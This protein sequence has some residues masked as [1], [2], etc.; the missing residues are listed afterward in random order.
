MKLFH[1]K[2]TWFV[3]LLCAVFAFVVAE[4]SLSTNIAFAQGPTNIYWVNWTNTIQRADGDGSNVQTLA[5]GSN[6]L[7]GIAVDVANG[8]IYWTSV[9]GGQI[10]R[11]DLV[12]SNI[13]IVVAGLSQPSDIGLD[14][15]NNHMYWTENNAGLIKRSNLDG[16]NVQTLINIPTGPKELALDL[17]NN[18]IYWMA[19]AAGVMRANLDG[20]NVQTIVAT[21][22]SKYGMAVDPAN[23]YIF[24]T[25]YGAGAVY[26][27]NLDG[28]N[29]QTIASG[30]G[31]LIGLEVDS[32]NGHI[33]FTSQTLGNIHR[34]NLDGSNVQTIISGLN[35]PRGLALGFSISPGSPSLTMPSDSIQVSDNLTFTVPVILT[36]NGINLP[37]IGFSVDYDQTCATFNEAD[38]DAD[39]LFDAIQD[40]PSGF[41]AEASHAI[42]DTDG[43][44]DIAIYYPISPTVSLSDG[45]IANIEFEVKNACVTTD[46]SPVNMDFNF[47]NDPA[48][49]FA[50]PDG[51]DVPGTSEDATIPV[52]FNT[53]P[54]DIALSATAIDENLASGTV[55]GSLST[56]DLEPS[57]VHSYSLTGGDVGDFAINGS[58]LE[59]AA[60]FNFEVK[61]SYAISITT[62][63]GHGGTFEKE[64]TVTVNDVNDTPTSVGLSN[65]TIN[66]HESAGTAVGA[67]V[68]VD[69]DAGATHTYAIVGGDTADFAINGADLETAAEFNYEVKASYAI[70]VRTTD[71][72][73][74]TY[75]EAFTISVVDINDAPVALNDPTSPI[76]SPIIIDGPTIIDVLA[77]DTDE[78]P[79]DTLTVASVTNG[80]NGSVVNNSTDV[81]YTP[82]SATF[83]GTD[84]F[85]YVATDDNGLGVLTDGATVDVAIVASDPRGDCNTSGNVGI[86]DLVAIVIEFFDGD[87]NNNW[88]EIYQAGYPGSP[89]GCDANASQIIGLSD[90]SC[91]VLVFFGNTSCTQGSIVA[92]SASATAT[93]AI[94]GAM[95][96]APGTTV[97]VPIKLDSNGNAVAAAGFA[98]DFDASQFSF[99]TTDANGDGTPDAVTFHTPASMTTYASYNAAESRVEV[100]VYGISIPLPTLNDGLIATI[101]LQ[102]SE[103]A[104]GNT[105][106]LDLTNGSMGNTAGQDVAVEAIGSSVTINQVL[107]SIFL[108]SLRK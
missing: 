2:H 18:H 76:T 72:G 41:T 26:R 67:L 80:S 34:A 13:Q 5:S 37:S 107:K 86:A 44:L 78:D 16:S 73:G 100:A 35:Q 21:S 36:T 54:T 92:A 8:H 101:E 15:A 91:T 11:S 43:E 65:A 97:S 106:D 47:S 53:S 24:W 50:N 7:T 45:V 108:P 51:N 94:E 93:L 87:S 79:A 58:D 105:V 68:S 88:W 38:V 27:A 74:D 49:E 31:S 39:D 17:T 42:T 6:N 10:F 29:S 28:S 77:N 40:A 60:S 46:G 95:T 23:G 33:Y 32:A 19:S 59:T 71:N 66:E 25:D 4:I 81:T 85:T 22:G 96:A 30:Q 9:F 99:D 57:D 89:R 12:G 98:L 83:N 48:P 75:D 14:V 70:I 90:I 103:S 82:A 62:D 55:V 3:A 20:A 84:S 64:F 52:Q 1:K 102:V 104:T 56:S 63:D 69:E 61:S